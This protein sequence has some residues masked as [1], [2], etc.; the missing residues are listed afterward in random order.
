MTQV[1]KEES[2]KELVKRNLR[3]AL[4]MFDT[5]HDDLAYKLILETANILATELKEN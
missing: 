3:L 5:D 4:A 2:S 1:S